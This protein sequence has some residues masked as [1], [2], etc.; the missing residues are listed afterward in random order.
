M[1]AICSAASC[2]KRAR[3]RAM[4]AASICRSCAALGPVLQPRLRSAARRTRRVSGARACQ[5]RNDTA[6]EEKRRGPDEAVGR[7]L[8]RQL[9]RATTQVLTVPEYAT[10]RHSPPQETAHKLRATDSAA[11]NG[12]RSRQTRA[13]E[14]HAFTRS[15]FESVCAC[16]SRRAVCAAS[17]AGSPLMRTTCRGAGH[18]AREFRRPQSRLSPPRRHQ[19]SGRFESERSKRHA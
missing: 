8:W 17:S 5:R 16:A 13:P 18:R 12:L 10:H 2:G 15:R 4:A 6:V 11:L 7:Q 19:S 14:A 9:S 3:L 1:A